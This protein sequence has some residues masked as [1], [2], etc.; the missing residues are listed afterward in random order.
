[1]AGSRLDYTIGVDASDGVRGVKQFSRAVRDELST[2]E[3]NLDDTS[4]AGKRAASV[5]SAMADDVRTELEAASRASD[6]LR[7]ALGEVGERTDVG[8]IIA[9]L[10]RMGLSFDEI[11]AVYGAGY[12]YR[13][14]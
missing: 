12:R 14:E 4:S 11:E 6:A 13:P 5:I 8:S 1:M 10:K 2:V 7:S 9:D 3:D